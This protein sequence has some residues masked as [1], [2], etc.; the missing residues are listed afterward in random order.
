VI[1]VGVTSVILLGSRRST[2]EPLALA[3]TA[4]GRFVVVGIETDST[5]FWAVA[6]KYGAEIA[7]IEATS[8]EPLAVREL[9]AICP[10]T[11]IMLL[12]DPTDSRLLDLLIAGADGFFPQSS[13][14]EMIVEAALMLTETGVLLPAPLSRTVLDR[15][16]QL[17]ARYGANGI[18]RPRLGK[19][20][21]LVLRMLATGA[22]NREIARLL[23]VSVSTIKN[24]V[25]AIFR[26]LG[27]S[28][29]SEAVALAFRLGM[30]EEPEST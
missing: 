22:T 8:V 12:G 16:R 29:R 11:K 25:A 26:K 24:Q 30:A 27:A 7:V 23:G 28:N 1:I 2:L 14:P 6:L 19:R 5:A 3:L 9:L 13:P 20:E 15:L 21:A 18:E 17:E 4:G 10:G